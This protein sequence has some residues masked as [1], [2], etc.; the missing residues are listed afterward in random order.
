MRH[1]WPWRD[2]KARRIIE[3]GV[4]AGTV[5]AIATFVVLYLQ[6]GASL[7]FYR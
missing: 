3:Y 4:V 7:P 5:A 1:S 6:W 2:P